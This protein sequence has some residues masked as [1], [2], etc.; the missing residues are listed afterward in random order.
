MNLTLADYMDKAIPMLTQLNESK[1]V[2]IMTDDPEVA[3]TEHREPWVQQGYVLEV[4]SGHNQYSKETY[5]D[6]D[7]FLESLYAAEA[8]RA[9]VGHYISTVSLLVFRK[10]CARWGECPIVDM[11]HNPPQ[12]PTT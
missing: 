2:F 3:S 10:M 9:M 6:Y 4:I 8:C 1:H 7:P 5:S 12:T 11:M